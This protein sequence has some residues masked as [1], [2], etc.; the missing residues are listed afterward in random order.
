MH[1]K[2]EEENNN[3]DDDD[4]DDDEDNYPP[5]YKNEKKIKKIPWD[6]RKNILLSKIIKIFYNFESI[7]KKLAK[8][9][10]QFYL[11]CD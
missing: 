6:R 2:Q 11:G 4:D 10:V 7:F 8:L 5:T 3:N 9:K 1:L